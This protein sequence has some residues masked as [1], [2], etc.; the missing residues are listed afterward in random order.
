MSDRPL[1]ELRFRIDT[2]GWAR[3][4]AGFVKDVLPFASSYALNG[5]LFAARDALRDEAKRVFD[6]PVAFTVKN[7][8]GYNMARLDRRDMR[9]R[10][11]IKD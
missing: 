11:F 8:F 1:V 4:L 5:T 10:I 2:T 6:R 3:Q 7:A 9:A